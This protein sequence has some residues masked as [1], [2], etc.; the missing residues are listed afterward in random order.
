MSDSQLTYRE[1]DNRSI[2]EATAVRAATIANLHKKLNAALDNLAERGHRMSLSDKITQAK[3]ALVA[4][5]DLQGYGEIPDEAF[6]RVRADYVKLL[7]ERDA[8]VSPADST[9]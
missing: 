9:S 3:I 7:A 8:L 1:I 2:R 5:L 4:A 6:A